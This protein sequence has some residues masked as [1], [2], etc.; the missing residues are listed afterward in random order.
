VRGDGINVWDLS[1]HKNFIVRE[2]LTV[3]FRAEM[4]GAMNTPNYSPP[5]TN[6]VSTLFGQVTN[7][8]TG[9]EERRLFVTLR[10]LF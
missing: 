8:Q 5:N 3:Q 9:Q 6:P 1:A 2:R 7:T 4:E 10:L